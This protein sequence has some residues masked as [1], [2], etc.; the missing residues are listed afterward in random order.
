LDKLYVVEVHETRVRTYHI[1]AKSKEDAIWRYKYV[2]YQ[3]LVDD[4]CINEDITGV[5]YE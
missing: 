5:T 1:N 4:E 3:K 2:P